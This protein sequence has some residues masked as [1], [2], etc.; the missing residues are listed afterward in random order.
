MKASSRITINGIHLN[1][2]G[3]K[4]VAGDH[5]RFPVSGR[6]RRT[7]TRRVRERSPR[8]CVDKNFHWFNRYRT[9]DG[10]SIFGGRA[11]LKFVDGQT[12]RE[13]AQREMEILDVMTANRDKNSLGRGPGQDLKRVDDSNI[14]AVHPGHH[15]Q[16][17]PGPRTASTC[18]SAAKKRSAEDD[19]RQGAE[20]QPVRLGGAVPRTGQPGADG[21]RH[22]GPAVG[23]RLADAIRTGSRRSR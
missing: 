20:G 23:R 14:P 4:I 3:N 22:Q 1:E 16:A 2:T 11:D 15:Q 8:P 19:R 9:I 10:Y 12:N 7:A 21:V 13:V 5:R 6:S 18:S 17:G